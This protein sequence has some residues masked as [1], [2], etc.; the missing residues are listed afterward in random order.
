MKQQF[1]VTPAAQAETPVV[2]KT[3]KRAAAAQRAKQAS[4]NIDGTGQSATRQPASG[5]G[6]LDSVIKAAIA[7]QQGQ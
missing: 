1:G 6:D 4:S 3:D 2:E 7:S 5:S